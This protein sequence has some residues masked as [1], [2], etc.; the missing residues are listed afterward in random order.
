MLGKK[1]TNKKSVGSYK[2]KK[3]LELHEKYNLRKILSSQ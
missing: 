2:I 3:T 1:L